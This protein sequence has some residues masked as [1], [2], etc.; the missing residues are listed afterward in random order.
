M[1]DAT[2]LKRSKAKPATPQ[3][4]S[5]EI[6]DP[7]KQFYISMASKFFMADARQRMYERLASPVEAGVSIKVAIEQMY[8]RAA[9]K[10]ESETQAVVLRHVLYILN[11]G[12]ALSDGLQPFIPLNE[13]MLIRAGEENGALSEA[14]FQAA[15]TI[16]AQKKVA[17]AI[18]SALAK[19]MLLGTV[20]FVAMYVIGAHV[21]PQMAE[22]LPMDE[23]RGQAQFLATI[24][25]IVT[26]IW[27]LVVLAGVG[28]VITL[29]ILSLKRWSGKGRRFADNLPPYSLYRVLQ[30]AGWLTTYAAML[31][32]GR[33]IRTIL[34]ELEALADHDG[35]KY[36]A[37]RTMKIGIENELGAENIGIA[38]ER[39][40][41][42]F[43]DT[44]LIADL[45]MQ[46]S[47]TNFDE[48][49]SVL[50]DRWINSTVTKVQGIASIMNA[51]A[52]V[53]LAIFIGSFVM[54]V[55]TLNQQISSSMGGF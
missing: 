24:S 5:V 31:Q 50:A 12:G 19:P 51:M 41:T 26:S 44:E 17:A 1:S 7:G 20:L 55:I 6:R 10:S 43:P 39:A 38:M 14:L 23:W 48:R 2:Q 47:L 40:S 36:L 53:V 35:N 4:V 54:G 46:S 16:E 27:F 33:P 18:K 28:G 30:G 13:Q 11:N 25:G 37:S 42:N 8:Q 32:A 45:V 9:F 34:D 52:L 21:A 3:D 49:I 22:I 15:G 29:S